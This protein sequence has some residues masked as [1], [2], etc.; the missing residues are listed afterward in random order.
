MAYTCACNFFWQNPLLS[1]LP[2]VPLYKTRA[3]ELVADVTPGLLKFPLV[4]LAEFDKGRN[5]PKGGC[6]R[7]S[8]DE[9]AHAIIFK[10]AERL[11]D[12]ANAAEKKA[13]L[14]T[15]LS[16]PVTFKHLGSEDAV[17]AEANS[18]RNDIQGKARVVT[19]SARQLVYNIHGFKVRHEKGGKTYGAKEIAKFWAEHV[20]L[21][22]GQDFMRKPGTIDTCLTIHNRLLSIPECEKM[23]Q[24]SEAVYGAEGPWASIWTLQEFISRCGTKQK[25]IWVMASI[26]DWLQQGKIECRDVTSTTMKSGGRSSTDIAL[27]TLSLKT[28]LLGPWLDSKDLLPIIKETA[29]DIFSS[30]AAYRAKYNPIDGTVD[31]NWLFAWPKVGSM[32]L[33]FLEQS[34][35]LHTGTEEALMR[36]AIHI[37]YHVCN[38]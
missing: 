7:V 23:L 28:Y 8:P 9:W 38:I 27:T 25:M 21:S 19:H 35:F 26:A 18:L 16:C 32:V 3:M 15:L 11:N 30:H 10:V 6:M 12:G 29:R 17:Y 1:P 31:T 2:W 4:F 14:R 20:R 36:Q 24:D 5:L 34:L 22:P 13:W 37:T 33:S